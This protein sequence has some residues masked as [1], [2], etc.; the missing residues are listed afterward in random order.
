MLM[1]G[2]KYNSIVHRIKTCKLPANLFVR[3]F[4]DK[5]ANGDNSIWLYTST[6][7]PTVVD[8]G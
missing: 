7:H 2:Y 6:F 5:R 4:I 3:H 1:H 8:F